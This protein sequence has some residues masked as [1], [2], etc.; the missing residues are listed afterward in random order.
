MLRHIDPL[1]ATAWS[2]LGGTLFLLP[3]G[4]WE[5]ATSPA[6]VITAAAVA[7]VLYS[8]VF[9]AGTANVLVFH[10][11]RLVGPARVSSMQFLVPAVA[12]LFGAVFLGEVVG[13]AQVLGGVV[14]VAGVWMARRP[15]V[16]PARLRSRPR[17]GG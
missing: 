14:I 16:I 10:A 7:G 2:V 9:A 5:T 12:V 1:Q 15:T 4:A 17:V 11:I 13:P 8:G 3:F 6:V